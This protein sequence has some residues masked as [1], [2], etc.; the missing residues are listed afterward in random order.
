M[1][2][3]VESG[4]CSCSYVKGVS[5]GQLH[6]QYLAQPLGLSRVKKRERRTDMSEDIASNEVDQ[7]IHFGLGIS[8][9]FPILN[10]SLVLL[11]PFD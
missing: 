1:I 3:Y 6:E 8:G 4:A 7:R 10:R 9:P 5:S 2:V 11:D